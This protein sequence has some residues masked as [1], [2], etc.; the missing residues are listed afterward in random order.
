MD[1][2]KQDRKE[3]RQ[4]NKVLLV[5]AV[6]IALAVLWYIGYVIVSYYGRSEHAA[7]LFPCLSMFLQA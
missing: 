7:M 1:T 2:R 4:N 6:A 3:I 5:L